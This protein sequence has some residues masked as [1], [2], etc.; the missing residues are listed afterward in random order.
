MKIL[1]I[2]GTG[3]I[4]APLAK[5]LAK[6]GYEI[7]VTTRKNRKS[8]KANIHFLQ[9]D[10]KDDAF[11][12]AALFANRYDAI[13]DFGHWDIV[14]LKRWMPIFL[15]ATEHYVYIS[16]SRVYVSGDCITESTLRLRDVI[17]DEIAKWG[18]ANVKAF[19]EDILKY[20][21]SNNWT[22]V[23]PYITYNSMRLQLGI[24][25]KEW[26][27]QSIINDK[28]ILIPEKLLGCTTTMTYAN[29]VAARIAE[30]IIGREDSKGEVYQIA[31]SESHTWKEVLDIYI[32]EFRQRGYCPRIYVT[33]DDAY[34]NYFFDNDQYL[35]DRLYVRRFDSRKINNI[36]GINVY[37][38]LQQGI[39]ASLDAFFNNGMAFQAMEAYNQ[40]CTYIEQRIRWGDCKEYSEDKIDYSDYAKQKIICFGAGKRLMDSLDKLQVQYDILFIVDNDRKKWHQKINDDIVIYSPEK[41]REYKDSICVIT[42]D[43][44][45]DAFV[46]YNQASNYGVNKIEHLKNMIM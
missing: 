10:I 11:L 13:I 23:R 44:V 20:N 42:I 28:P 19:G 9:G 17:G 16:S 41:L 4:G 25:E 43:N 6:N 21:D 38:S 7:Y 27:L 2:C 15:M 35:H 30:G 32:E 33:E 5:I 12:N 45:K 29:D 1:L 8:S 31:T 22:I 24:Y 14:D 39:K 36:S 46:L 26:W 18:A 37:T 40:W 3:A 34:I